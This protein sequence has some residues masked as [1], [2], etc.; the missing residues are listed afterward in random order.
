MSMYLVTE[1]NVDKVRRF[2]IRQAKETESLSITM[3]VDEIAFHSSVSL[4]TA[5]KALQALADEGFLEIIRGSS[6]RYTITY[7][8]KGDLALEE[9]RLSIADEIKLKDRQIRELQ[10]QVSRLLAENKRLRSVP[11]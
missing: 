11:S 5:H 7:C 10:E 1:D 3:R 6:R 8:I 4:T 9:G 2:M